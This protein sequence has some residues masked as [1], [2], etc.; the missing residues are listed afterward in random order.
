MRRIL[1]LV[2]FLLFI[3]MDVFAVNLET[4]SPTPTG[5]WNYG[6][7]TLEIPNS[8]SLPASCTIGQQYM[9]SDATSGQRFY[10]CESTDTWALQGDGSGGDSISIDGAAVVDP[11]FVS[12]GD[13]DFVNTS[14]TVTANI[15][16][17]LESIVWNAAGITADGIQCANAAK[18]TINSGPVMYT[19]ICTDNDA[20]SMYGHVIMPDSYNGGTL[21][22]ELEYLQT[23]AETNVLNSD[24]AA[25]CRGMGETVSSTWGTEIAIDDAAVSGSNIVDHTTSAA[26][27]PAG[28]CA[29]GD[30][31]WWR[32]QLDATGTTTAVATLYFMGVKMEY[33]SNVGD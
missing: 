19:I 32:I 9:D 8:A 5:I 33:T 17:R 14:N 23:A 26:V 21:T 24:V 6:G 28:T 12:T 20:S 30:S 11:D 18:V 29:G 15:N 31:L 16:S 22:F 13:I 1:F 4:I 7:G 3:T 25:Q 10:L 2:L 27:T